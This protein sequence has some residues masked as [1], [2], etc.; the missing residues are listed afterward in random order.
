MAIVEIDATL[1]GD[2][3]ATAGANAIYAADSTMAGDSS[4]TMG[5]VMLYAAA[6]SMPGE[7]SSSNDGAL[8]DTESVTFSA[9]SDFVSGAAVTYAALIA[10]AGN[11]GLAINPALVTLIKKTQGVVVASPPPTIPTIRI[12]P[13]APPPPSYSVGS[14]GE[15]PQRRRGL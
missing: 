9:D 6:S 15:T 10:M 5:A 3:S 1:A 8:S 2:S 14:V 11:S 12:V 4:A 13:Q 7:A